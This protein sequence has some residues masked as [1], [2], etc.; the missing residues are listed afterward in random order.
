MILNPFQNTKASYFDVPEI[1]ENWVDIGK[2][3]FI[4]SVM[5]PNS[6]TPIRIFGGK[7]TGKTHILRYFS[8]QSQKLR[9]IALK[10]S[11]L[12]QIQDDKY[13]GI[14][15]EANGLEVNR[16]SGCGYSDEEW[17]TVFYYF[18][19]L[20]LIEH[21][22]K[23]IDE[24]INGENNQFD[25]SEVS[26]YFF[27]E[28]MILSFKTI[29]EFYKFIKNERK[30]IDYQVGDLST[31]G[32]RTQLEIK[33]LFKIENG[34]KD[35]VKS[36]LNTVE[37]LKN[38]RILYIIDEIE[39][40][41][42]EQL[43]YI[44]SLVRHIGGEHNISLRLA[45]RLYGNRT[46]DTLDAGQKLLEGAE[47]KTIYLEKTLE[48]NF[49]NF[50]K[51]L[52]QKR[53]EIAYGDELKVDFSKTLEKRQLC[54]D[55]QLFELMSIHNGKERFHIK[56]L[57]DSLSKYKKY[58]QMQVD[59]IITN[60]TYEDNW[61]IEK[62][63]IFLLF[64]KWDKELIDESIKIKESCEKYVKNLKP[65]LHEN[66][67]EKY[68]QD[69]R[70]QLFRDYG[71][72][73]SYSG[74]DEIIKMSNNNPRIFLSILDNLFKTCQFHDINLLTADSISCKVQ[75]Q[76]L[77]ESSNWFWN[78]FTTEV[79]EAS[80]LR[81]CVGLCEFFRAYRR[82]DKP[83]EK[84]AVIFSFDDKEALEVKKLIDMAI[85]N[86]LLIK[87]KLRKDRA[88]G[89]FLESLR[90]H[91]MLSPKWELPVGAGGNVTLNKEVLVQ[92]F[93]NTK[94]SN[95]DECFKEKLQ[96]LNIPFQNSTQQKSK[97]IKKKIMQ[98]SLFE[99]EQND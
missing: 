86:S 3:K 45:G 82:S 93:L 22:L 34:F 58:N 44:N 8:F 33:P 37:P 91:P 36:I 24:M 7:G 28:E 83:V 47:I 38:I 42:L 88:T 81:A 52:Y 9:A 65:N 61:L 87:Q 6:L 4:D 30:N 12:E 74:Y 39:N 40:F 48:P 98:A 49:A 62:M 29:S 90:L 23:K 27:H 75:D 85:D 46:D 56:S 84:H 99:V 41:S 32:S 5:I 79:T 63:S 43:K 60:I 69:M 21:V 73:I 17:K 15:I 53:V 51:A 80:V 31:P 94:D 35:I 72:G 66:V 1:I 71:R 77:I 78:N 13:I 50:A 25:F 96:P 89:K 92:L 18:F 68:G 20:E 59:T 55:T 10:K 64:Q 57:K 19:N 95:L 54:D 67:N 2:N 76:A 16:F 14:Y 97:P 26:E 70:Y 11:I